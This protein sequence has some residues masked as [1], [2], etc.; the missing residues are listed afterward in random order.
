MGG[1]W[2][3]MLRS[4][5]GRGPYSPPS[6]YPAHREKSFLPLLF[7]GPTRS[8]ASNCFPHLNPSQ[9]HIHSPILFFSKITHR[10]IQAMHSAIRTLN[11]ARAAGL[12]S[13]RSSSSRKG[14]RNPPVAHV[15][16]EE[17]TQLGVDV[18]VWQTASKLD[19]ARRLI[20]CSGQWLWHF[21]GWKSGRWG[22]KGA[23]KRAW[24]P[25]HSGPFPTGMA[26]LSPPPSPQPGCYYS[27][28][29]FR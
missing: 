18:E 6:K 15:G 1:W 4:V 29:V 17:K 25:I 21:D 13:S 2:C 27:P 14:K 19:L 24:P 28:P 9:S 12:V 7:A 26:S 3:A 23:E 16:D 5:A 10:S 22:A 8:S 11:V 20:G